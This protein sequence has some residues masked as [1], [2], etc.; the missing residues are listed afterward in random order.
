MVVI[1]VRDAPK[2]CCLIWLHCHPLALCVIIVVY[3]RYSQRQCEAVCAVL[4]E[5]LPTASFTDPQVSILCIYMYMYIVTMT[6]YH[7]V[8]PKVNVDKVD[9]YL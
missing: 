5:K 2:P 7:A 9:L 8:F 6:V 4:R 1:A 3:Q